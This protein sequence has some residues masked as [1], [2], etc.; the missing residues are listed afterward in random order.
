MCPLY[1]VYSQTSFFHP[2]CAIF[3]PKFQFFVPPLWAV[4]GDSRPPLSPSLRHCLSVCLCLNISTCMYVSMYVLPLP[5]FLSRSLSLSSS[6]CVSYY[7]LSV[8]LS[9]SLYKIYLLTAIQRKYI[10]KRIALICI[11]K[12]MIRKTRTGSGYLC[13]ARLHWATTSSPRGHEKALIRKTANNRDLSFY[14]SV[15]LSV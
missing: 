14:L 8:C 7:H 13:E 2:L 1:K 5:L 9:L 10:S 6:L 3:T 15:R 11:T 4:P 12:H